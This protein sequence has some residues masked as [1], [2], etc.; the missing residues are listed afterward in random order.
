[1]DDTQRRYQGCCDTCFEDVLHS[2]AR[3]DL[4]FIESGVEWNE[5]NKI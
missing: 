5:P 2:C 1:M 4:E 3:L